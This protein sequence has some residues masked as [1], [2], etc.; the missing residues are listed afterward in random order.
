MIINKI[1][2]VLLYEKKIN[3][4]NFEIELVIKILLYCRCISSASKS[5][6]KIFKVMI[7]TTIS[8]K[9]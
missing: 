9:Y 6:M 3:K 4:R 1:L 8:E 7:F 2:I 5:I